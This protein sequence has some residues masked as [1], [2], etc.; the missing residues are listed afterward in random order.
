[1]SNVM[2]I[3][4]LNKKYGQNGSTKVTIEELSLE[5]AEREFLCI[6]GPSGCG[7][8]TLLRCIAGFENYSGTVYVDDKKVYALGI[9]RIMVFQDFNKLFPWKTVEDNIKYPLKLR[10]VKDKDE[11]KRITTDALNKVRL[12]D[13]EKLYPYQLSGGMKQRVAIAKAIALKP[14]IILMDE[15]FAALDA[16]TRRDL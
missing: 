3:E 7:K 1:M 15:P 10:G 12:F 5:I 11:L 6:L 8:T 14:K 4:N 9:D 13:C 2:T 16:M